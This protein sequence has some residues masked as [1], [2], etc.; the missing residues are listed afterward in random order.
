MKI[1][2]AFLLFVLIISSETFSQASHSKS[3]QS[4]YS[5]KHPSWIMQGNIY[6]VNVRQYTPQGICKT[7]RPT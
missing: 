4:K 1:L 2:Y 3:G 5:L 6:E 7:F